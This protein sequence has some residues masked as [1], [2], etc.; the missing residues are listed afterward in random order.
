ME[1]LKKIREKVM[2]HDYHASYGLLFDKLTDVLA[3]AKSE[4]NHEAAY[5]EVAKDMFGQIAA[6]AQHCAEELSLFQKEQLTEDGQDQI[7]KGAMELL[8]LLLDNAAKTQ[9]VIQNPHQRDSQIV[10][11]DL[12]DNL[13]HEADQFLGQYGDD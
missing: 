8:G 5:S 3:L 4:D 6:V 13:L 7:K 10:V 1:N 11:F 12:D 9:M 2:C